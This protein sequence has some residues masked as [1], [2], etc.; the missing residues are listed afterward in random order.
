MERQEDL[1]QLTLLLSEE[2]EEDPL[3]TWGVFIH[4][5]LSV[6]LGTMFIVG[7]LTYAPAKTKVESLPT[8]NLLG[9]TKSKASLDKPSLSPALLSTTMDVSDNE[10]VPSVLL[11]D[12]SLPPDVEDVYHE[13]LP[14]DVYHYPEPPEVDNTALFFPLDSISDITTSA[15]L[16][17]TGSADYGT[18]VSLTTSS[19]L[20]GPQPP[21]RITS[22]P[23]ATKIPLKTKEPLKLA[24]VS[25]DTVVATVAR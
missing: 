10:V 14:L 13:D 2:R 3:L 12:F 5:G 21:A 19:E 17:T 11:P 23:A 8:A 18:T 4:L 24:K 25:V 20:F 1:K 9:T 6:L 22:K 15:L 16:T 7:T